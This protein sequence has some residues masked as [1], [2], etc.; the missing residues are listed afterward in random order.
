MCQ[1]RQKSTIEGAVRPQKIVRQPDAEQQRKAD[2]HV[3]IAAE[4]AIDLH[5]EA[6]DGEQAA[7]ALSDVGLA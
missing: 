4:I 5:R 3:G 2:R 7:G 6:V 1:R